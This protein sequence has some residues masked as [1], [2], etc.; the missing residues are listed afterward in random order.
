MSTIKRD[1]F[2]F[3]ASW[4]ET[5]LVYPE[6]QQLLMFKAIV[7]MGLN[8]DT[9]IDTF[10][11]SIKPCMILIKE[12]MDKMITSYEK[13]QMAG[14][15]GMQSR[16]K[17]KNNEFQKY[18]KLWNTLSDVPVAEKLNEQR[19]ELIKEFEKLHTFEDF[20][21]LIEIVKESD[22]LRGKNNF[23]FQATFDW[24]LV[25]KN[26]QKCIEGNYKNKASKNDK[27]NELWEQ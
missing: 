15:R 13:K 22:F 7:E 2:L 21:K 9:S 10:P 16:W 17:D 24:V 11:Q 18:L 26:Y 8:P 1:H 6:N 14:V 5:V 3:K 25:D 4:L 27:I 19:T 12:S 20:E 23:G